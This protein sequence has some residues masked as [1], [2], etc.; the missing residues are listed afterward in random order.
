MAEKLIEKNANSEANTAIEPVRK[1]AS[2]TPYKLDWSHVM[3]DCPDWFRDAKFGIFF[4]WGPYSVPEYDSEWYSRNMYTK[5][6]AA[7][8]YHEKT[9]GK[10]SDFGYK[11]LYSGLTAEKF[12]AAEWAKLFKRAGVRYFAP[13]A[14]HADGFSMWDS[15]VNQINSVNY[16]PKRDVLGELKVAA[17]A[18]GLKFG[19]TMHHSWLWGWFASTDPNADVYD[20]ANEKYYG[21]ALPYSASSANPTPLPDKAFNQ[22]WLDKNLE[23]V[24]KYL[25]D[26][27]YFDSRVYIIEEEY[28]LRF[29]EKYYEAARKAGKQVA[30]TYK[31]DDFH[32]GSGVRD[33]ECYWQP[34]QHPFPWQTDDKTVWYTWCHIANAQYKTPKF[35]IHQLCEVVSKNGNF[36][37]NVG[38]K[39]DGTFP[40]EMVANLYEIGDW[41]KVNG[42]G[43]YDTRIFSV[44]GE[45]PTR[46]TTDRIFHAHQLK[47]FTAEDIR[48]TRKG[49]T[50][51]AILLGWPYAGKTSIS[52]L[53]LGGELS[54]E[55]KRVTMLGD[56]AQLPFTRDDTALTVTLPKEK[57]CKH[58]YVL[59]I[60]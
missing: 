20:P 40:D 14:E 15:Q 22:N 32:D 9:Y 21:K 10:L 46:Q 31:Q 54:S 8:I 42:E 36:L 4:H 17:E 11:D 18:E 24:D 51:Y 52:P 6:H 60:E 27:M 47:D 43:I 56:G 29:M 53:R 3:H 39:K 44:Y 1:K 13:V 5:G 23:I 30:V 2:E 19:A 55:V 12:D 50:V 45:G 16:G 34:G 33:F 7:N 58:A 25:P 57:P 41:L 26:M 35:L 37:M 48:F 28:R 49:G 38:P 59:K